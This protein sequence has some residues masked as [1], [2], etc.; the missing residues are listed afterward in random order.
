MKRIITTI[1]APDGGRFVTI[2]VPPGEDVWEAPIPTRPAKPIKET[3]KKI[4]LTLT[5]ARKN[6]FDQFEHEFNMRNVRDISLKDLSEDTTDLLFRSFAILHSWYKYKFDQSKWLFVIKT[7]FP[8]WWYFYYNH[9]PRDTIQ[10]VYEKFLDWAVNLGT[11]G[12]YRPTYGDPGTAT[13]AQKHAELM[14]VIK[15]WHA[16]KIHF[17]PKN[18]VN[19]IRT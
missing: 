15:Y 19:S 2:Y 16:N 10:N 3:N 11:R 1:D 18:L 6:Y 5:E 12:L 7:Y 13:L 14:D 17:F 9:N 8:Y 4:N